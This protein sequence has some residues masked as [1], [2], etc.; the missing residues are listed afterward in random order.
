MDKD[1]M[2]AVL[3]STDPSQIA[4]VKMTLDREKIPYFVQGEIHSAIE[5]RFPVRFLVPKSHSNK[6]K[7]ALKEFL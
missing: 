5:A 7:E 6:A 3:S 2:V 4:L 1:K